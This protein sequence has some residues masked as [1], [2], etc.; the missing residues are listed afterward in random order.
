MNASHARRLTTALVATLLP[1][2]FPAPL[3][4]EGADKNPIPL[5]EVARHDHRKDCWMAIDGQVYDITDYLPRHPGSMD[6]VLE[7]CGREATEA[8]ETKGDADQP[9]V[10]SRGAHY[11]LRRYHLG[12]LAPQ[13]AAREDSP[14]AATPKGQ[15]GGRDEPGNPAAQEE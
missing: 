14:G 8:W 6:T 1:L 3:I 2:S 11:L 10:H 9:R 5:E 13:E 4:A 7:W 12:P 15:K